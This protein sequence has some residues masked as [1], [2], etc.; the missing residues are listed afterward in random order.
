MEVPY[1]WVVLVEQTWRTRG[2]LIREK[3][4][5]RPKGD[6]AQPIVCLE[7]GAP[8]ICAD[9]FRGSARPAKRASDEGR[10]RK[11][12]ECGKPP[13]DRFGLGD[14]TLGQRRIEL[15]LIAAFDIPLRLAVADE[16]QCP[17]VPTGRG[18]EKR[19]G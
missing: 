4:I 19:R 9:D 6:L 12:R 13:A 1:I 2:D 8:A 14:A 17:G 10:R 15:S 11:F 3:T 18:R 7:Y 16:E 5:P